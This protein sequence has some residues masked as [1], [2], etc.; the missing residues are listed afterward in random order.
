[1]AELVEGMCELFRGRL[2]AYGTDEGGCDKTGF[3]FRDDGAYKEYMRR[4]SLHLAGATPF[5]VYPLVAPLNRSEAEFHVRWGCTDLDYEPATDAVNIARIMHA[6][7]LNAWVERSRSKGYHVWTFASEWVPAEIMRNALLAV[8]QFLDIPAKEVNPKQ[9]R[10]QADQIGNYVRVPY[11]G[12]LTGRNG[13]RQTIYKTDGSNIY[14]FEPFVADALAQR[15]TAGDYA[16]VAA[17][18]VPPKPKQRIIYTGLEGTLEDVTPQ[19]NADAFN[20][21]KHGPRPGHDRSSSLARLAHNCRESGITPDQAMLVM[22]DADARWGKFSERA[23]GEAQL[24]RMVE[25]AYG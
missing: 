1:M 22:V 19:L 13:Y 2:D 17:R 14:G 9:T 7:G 12:I 3:E 24:Q 25:N 6:V 11:P 8:H 23:D 10:L 16:A 18:Y 4:M 21:W 20:A 5:G 15:N